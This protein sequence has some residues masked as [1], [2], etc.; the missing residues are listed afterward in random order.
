MR[1]ADVRVTHHQSGGCAFGWGEAQHPFFAARAVED[2]GP[3]KFTSSARLKVSKRHTFDSLQL[4]HLLLIRK[5]PYF[6][7]R[8]FM[9][10][11]NRL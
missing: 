6:E 8:F 5:K 3:L 1:H 7:Q 11:H 9:P 10:I 4:G 2:Q